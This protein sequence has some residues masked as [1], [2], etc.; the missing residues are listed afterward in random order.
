MA[1]VIIE[2]KD[3]F[4]DRN[5]KITE[6]SRVVFYQWLKTQPHLLLACNSKGSTFY[7]YYDF[8]IPAQKFAENLLEKKEVLVCQGGDAS[9]RIEVSE[10]AMGLETRSILR[11]GWH[12]RRVSGGVGQELRYGKLFYGP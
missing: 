10:L 6:E 9:G 11:K 4:Y 5:R 2:N 7:V 8:D 12:L 3:M 1:A